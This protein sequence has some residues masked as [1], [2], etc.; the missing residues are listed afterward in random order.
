[1][2][3][4]ALAVTTLASGAVTPPTGDLGTFQVTTYW[5][6]PESRFVGLPLTAPGLTASYR[7][8]FLYSARGVPMEGTG[9]GLGGE[10][11]H[12]A[13][14]NGGY[15]VNSAGVKTSPTARGWTHGPPIWRDGGWRNAAGAP[16]F[17]VTATAWSNGVG[18]RRLP[19]HDSFGRGPG[20]PV[21]AWHS[22]AT[23]LAVI[24]RG[25]IVY[26]EALRASPAHGCFSADDTGGAIIGKH[27]DV[28]VPPDNTFIVPATS[29]VTVLTPTDLCPPP[30]APTSLGTLALA[31]VREP[32]AT[33]ATGR[34]AA[35]PGASATTAPEDFLYGPRGVAWAGV[36]TLNA[37][38]RIVSDGGGWW[39][40]R[41]GG[42]TA[43]TPTGAWTNGVA[44]WR[45]GGWR[46]AYGGPTFRRRNGRWSNGAGQT[47]LPYHDRFHLAADGERPPWQSAGSRVGIRGAN[48]GSLLHV[49]GLPSIGCLIVD[50]RVTTWPAVEILVPSGTPLG[51]LPTTSPVSALPADEAAAACAS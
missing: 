32:L 3:L 10:A 20:V 5:F 29:R 6:V 36:G 7:E 31:Y 33:R 21:T 47:R 48:P 13:A 12:F 27:I 49:D 11:V 16:T 14:T 37:S 46:N 51:S 38:N 8:D 22:I 42:R 23:D 18:K 45:E 41:S 2:V 50:H 17:H 19:Y 34:A 30:V 40:N 15:W 39:V 35:I 44:A 26:V 1:M 25:S 28:L 4:V 24:P 43:R 9:T